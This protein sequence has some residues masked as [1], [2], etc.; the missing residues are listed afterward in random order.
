MS[1]QQ[2]NRL[3]ELD[4]FRGLAALAVLLYHF[5]TR[6]DQMF[7]H[8]EELTFAFPHGHLGVDFFFII[9][10]FVIFLTLNRTEKYQDFLV[11]R[12][13]RLFPVYWF[14]VIFTYG[15][16]SIFGLPGEERTFTEF[17]INFTMIQE[18]F[19]V[20]DV[21]GV[22]W[23]LRYELIFYCIMLA[24]FL[25]GKIKNIEII[26]AA[27]LSLQFG[28]YAIE[29]FT[30]Y[31]PWKVK[32]FLLLEYCNL[33]IAGCVFNRIFA[34]GFNWQR[35]LLLLAALAAQY[36]VRDP[37]S[38]IAVGTFFVLFSLF[39]AGKLHFISFRP[40]IYLGTISYSLYLI[41]QNVSYVIFRELYELHV[42]QLA[43]FAISFCVV[44]AV[45]H[46]MTYYVERPALQ[47]IR[48]M[49]RKK[50]ACPQENLVTSSS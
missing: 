12:F 34:D 37:L 50:E 7:G 16:V 29:H 15:V 38:T 2:A 45:A 17:L 19:G 6:F 25:T 49:Y 47:L 43:I 10:G 28:A 11:S 22:Y 31:F 27:W 41:H 48:R 44:V 5:T 40:L 13:S 4:V 39:C 32:Q 14:A 9:S 24:I 8:P 26:C 35:I 30:G 46:F 42:P 33:F 3:S 20:K 18:F 36:L 21:D 23:T 1:E